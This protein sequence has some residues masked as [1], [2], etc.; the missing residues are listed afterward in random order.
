[1]RRSGRVV[2]ALL[3]AALVVT[4]CGSGPGDDDPAAPGGAEAAAGFPVTVTNCGRTLT[5]DAPPSRVVT[6]YQPVL[7]TLLALGLQDRIVGRVNFSENGPDGF[8]P[9]QKELYERIPQLSD[10]IAFPA[11]EV[12]LAQDAD[13]VI[14]EGWYNFE[15]SRGEATIDELTAAGTP[16][17]LTGGWCDDAG[18]RKFQLA[19]TL[20]DVRELGRIFGVPERAEQ[21]VAEM[22]KI[23]DEVRAAVAGR[24]AV[25]VLA[26][27][28]GAGPVRA[29][30]GAGLTQQLIEAAGGVNVLAGVRD[31]LIE[32][33]VEQV[34]ATEPTAII[35]TDY[36]PGPTAA[37]KFATVAAI[38]PESPAAKDKRYLPLPAAGQH[39][40]YRNILTLRQ[41]A[42]FL[43]PDAFPG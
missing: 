1:M 22:Q 40:G 12:L 20:R 35:V 28:G 19:D 27:D 31:D 25:P 3:A 34:A 26:T 7:E 6:G 33:G 30:G 41:V 13:L 4:G 5:F 9:G 2:G 38:V 36:L 39:P 42:A 32:V 15:A 21:V 37:E 14:S 18:Q 16:V 43:H 17:F 11:R 10:S 8:L 23:L 24:P 29:Y